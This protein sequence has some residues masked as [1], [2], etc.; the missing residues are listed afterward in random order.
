[1]R[2]P[3]CH[4]WALRPAAIVDEL[5]DTLFGNPSDDHRRAEAHEFISP[6]VVATSQEDRSG[7]SAQSAHSLGPVQQRRD[8]LHAGS[9]GTPD[10]EKIGA[11]KSYPAWSPNNTA[12]NAPDGFFM[13]DPD[14]GIRFVQKGIELGVP[15]FCIH[16]GLPIPAF[17]MKYLDPV[18]S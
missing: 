5:L 3:F 15:L 10:R 16:K 2:G 18:D 1:M 7:A 17:S 4:L 14:T 8:L 13:D 9:A 12:N 11:W 6:A